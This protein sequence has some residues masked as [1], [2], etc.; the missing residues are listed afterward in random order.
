MNFLYKHLGNN[1]Y[2][3]KNLTYMDFRF[4]VILNVAKVLLTT[5]LIN[6]PKFEEYIERIYAIP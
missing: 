4:V 5:C 3:C 1:E 2:L 6:Y